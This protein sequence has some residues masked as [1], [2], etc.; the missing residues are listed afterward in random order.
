MD[1]DLFLKCLSLK[2][3]ASPCL[4]QS[5]MVPPSTTSDKS[6]GFKVCILK[7]KGK[8]IILPNPI[9]THSIKDKI[10]EDSSILKKSKSS[11]PNPAGWRSKIFSIATITNS[12]VC[13]FGGRM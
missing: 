11:F 10:R 6:Y 4:S 9:E 1:H 12:N 5:S 3:E 2:K 13:E 7:G 8:K